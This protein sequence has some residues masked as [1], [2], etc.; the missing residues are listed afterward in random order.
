MAAVGL[1]CVR[2]I[3]GR[4]LKTKER[5]TGLKR[6]GREGRIPPSRV[7]SVLPL[8]TQPREVSSHGV[9]QGLSHGEGAERPR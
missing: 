6:S 1:F 4:T 7:D 9:P 5:E 2:A 8:A 3:Q